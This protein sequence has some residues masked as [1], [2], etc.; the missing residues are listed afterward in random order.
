MKLVIF[1]VIFLAFF[2]EANAQT[3]SP[4]PEPQVLV[5]QSFLNDATKAFALVV[6]LRDALEKERT[7][8][9]ATAV[10]KA[11]LQAQIDALNGLIVIKDRKEVVYQSL[12]DLRDQAFAVY[13]KVIKIQADMIERMSAQLNKGKSAWDKIVGVLKTVVSILAGAAIGGIVK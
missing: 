1:L 7:A 2:G 12:L 11:A 6:E 13:E 10:V 8:S 4:T 5:S 3:V 9:G